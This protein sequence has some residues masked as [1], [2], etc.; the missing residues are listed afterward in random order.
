MKRNEILQRI[1][2]LRIAIAY[3][4]NESRIMSVGQGICCNQEIASWFKVLHRIELEVITQGQAKYVIP[5]HIEEK[6]IQINDIVDQI[7]WERPLIF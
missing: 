1:D 3:S 2:Y 6:V 7:N 5:A 4:R